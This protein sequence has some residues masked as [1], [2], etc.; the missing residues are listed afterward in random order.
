MEH[1]YRAHIAELQ[2]RTRAVLER[3]QLQGL[4]IHS[5]EPIYAFLDDNTYP[6]KVNPHFNAWLPLTNVPHCW[7]QVDG[8]NRPRLFFYSPVDYWH[9]VEPVPQEYWAE[10]FEIVVLR[11]PRDIQQYLPAA[12]AEWGYIG[13][14]EQLAREAGIGQINPPALLNT[15]H[16]QRAYK[17]DY[18]LQ[19]M[20]S[21]QKI[22]VDGHRAAHDAF[23]AGMS[24]FDINLAY[25]AATGQSDT[26]VPYTNIVA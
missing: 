4:L 6:F 7:L 12:R 23:M 22:A 14:S 11:Q 20:R 19:C 2:S 13:S 26:E 16:Y 1:A 15:L 17:T 3:D 5:G 18:E 24:E 25:L 21:A 9:A 10:E 8:V